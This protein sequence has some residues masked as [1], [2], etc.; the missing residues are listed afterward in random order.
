M[1]RR[2]PKFRYLDLSDEIIFPLIKDE[3]SIF[4]VLSKFE[5]P[6]KTLFNSPLRI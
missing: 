6:W 2:R 3:L 4:A 1:R 5:R